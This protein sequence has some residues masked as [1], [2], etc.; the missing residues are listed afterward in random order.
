MSDY[1]KNLKKENG[2]TTSMILITIFLFLFVLMLVL[3]NIYLDNNIYY[4]SRKIAHYNHIYQTLL[5]EQK[6]IRHRLEEVKFQEN[7]S[8][9]EN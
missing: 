2:V 6:I 1:R 5:A 7:I 4:E 9:Q 3:P 8:S